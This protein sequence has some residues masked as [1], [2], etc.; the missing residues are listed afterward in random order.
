MKAIP[1]KYSL[2]L[3]N[4]KNKVIFIVGPTAVGKSEVAFYLAKKING[5]IVSCDSMQI[6]KK[7]GIL[8]SKPGPS[9]MKQ[10]KHYLINTV[11]PTKEYNVSRY[12]REAR[13]KIKDIISRG[14]VPVFVG[15]TGLYMSMVVDG[16]F[17]IKTP[18][19]KIRQRLYKEASVHGSDYLHARLKKI[20]PEAALKIH[21]NDAKRLIRALEVFEATGKPISLLQK[22]RIGIAKDYDVRM[23]CI[24]LPRED[25]YERIN[26]RVEKMFKQGLVKEVK[27]LLKMKLSRTARFAIGINE[28]APFLLGHYDLNSTKEK[29]KHSTRL[30]AKRQLTWFR[31]DKRIKWVEINKNDKVQKV[32]KRIWKELF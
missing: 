28:L 10:V 21:P 4:M 20:D 8:T 1:P 9:F 31:K 15:G 18:D 17:K 13:A 2:K 25:L 3:K 16:I 32:G 7:M 11:E 22:Q 14:K 19:K 27:R 30:Y 26:L 6:Y 29:M 23:F 5:E 12:T 24:N